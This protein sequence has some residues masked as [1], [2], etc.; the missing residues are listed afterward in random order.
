MRIIN[1]DVPPDWMVEELQK[2]Q[3]PGVQEREYLPVP[4]LPREAPKEPETPDR[5]VVVIPL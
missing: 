2:K 4:E 5:G 3:S 1:R